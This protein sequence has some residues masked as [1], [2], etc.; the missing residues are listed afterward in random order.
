MQESISDPLQEQ[1]MLLPAEPALQTL[2]QLIKYFTQV[3]SCIS[4]IPALSG[5]SWVNLSM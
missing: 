2:N 1:Q 3:Y 4:V 5:E